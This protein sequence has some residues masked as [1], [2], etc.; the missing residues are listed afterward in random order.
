MFADLDRFTVYCLLYDLSYIEAD[1]VLQQLLDSHHHHVT[2]SLLAERH[3]S[4]R[5]L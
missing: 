5:V 4:A 2:F 1:L 3:L